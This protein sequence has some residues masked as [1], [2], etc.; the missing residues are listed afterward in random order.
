MNNLFDHLIE[1][2][3]KMVW[4]ITEGK[5]QKLCIELLLFIPFRDVI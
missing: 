4:E 5:T 3:P 1:L 2:S